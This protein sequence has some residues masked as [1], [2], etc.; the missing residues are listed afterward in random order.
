MPKKKETLPEKK[1]GEAIEARPMTEA[2]TAALEVQEEGYDKFKDP[3]KMSGAELELSTKEQIKI[4]RG[5]DVQLCANFYYLLA[6][7]IPTD[8][9]YDPKDYFERVIGISYPRVQVMSA[10]WSF[11]VKLGIDNIKRLAKAHVSWEKLKALKPAVEA[12]KINKKNIEQWLEKCADPETLTSAIEKEVRGLIATAKREEMDETLKT[13]SFKIP[14]YEMKIIQLFEQIAEKSLKDADRGKWYLKAAMLFS[15]NYADELDLKKWKALGLATLRE[16]A[17]RTAPVACIFV[18]LAP[19][20]SEKNLGV[21][22]VYYVYQG[23]GAPGDE[24]GA[25]REVRHCIASSVKEAKQFL[26]VE[27]VREFKLEIAPSFMPKEPFSEILDKPKEKEAEAQPITEEAKPK[28]AKKA[29]KAAKEEEA[30][31]EPEKAAEKEEEPPWE[32]G[33]PREEMTQK[34][35]RERI[36]AA[37]VKLTEAHGEEKAKAL[38][39]EAKNELKEKG[40]KGL[41]LERAIMEWIEKKVK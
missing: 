34:Q 33:K 30:L 7:D 2:E 26:G 11:L 22:P 20:I 9:G 18:P 16:L 24:E 15:D 21:A 1:K 36:T 39:A 31:P 37:I 12:G 29:K 14:A 25:K 19:D 23:F 41:D 35:I 40:V 5:S 3:S 38:Y 13:V 28:K 17:E 10:I 6:K 4:R 8:H 27:N 32:E